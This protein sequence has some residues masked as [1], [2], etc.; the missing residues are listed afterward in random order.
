M[1][2][3]DYE[4]QVLN[5]EDQDSI[6]LIDFLIILAKNKKK[7]F[8]YPIVFGIVGLAISFAL[9]KVYRANI[10]VLPPQQSQSTASA[11]LGQLGSLG[12]AASASLGIKSQN[13]LYIALLKSR[14]LTDKIIKR[15]D[16]QKRYDEEYLE[17]TRKLLDENS[18]IL[19]GKD[20]II[21]I[22]VDDKDPDIAAQIANAYVEELTLLT[23]KFALT[24]ASQRRVFYEKQLELAKDKIIAAE[25]ALSSG[26]DTKGIM[27]VDAQSKAV[28]E[29][30]ARLRANIS[31]KQIQLKAM[32][33][34]VTSNN[35]DYKR[36]NQELLGMQNELAKL[37]N[38]FGSESHSKSDLT[39]QTTQL[40]DKSDDS[41]LVGSNNIELLR[42]VKY[43]QM[44]YEMLSKQYEIARLDEAKDIPI[45]Q[46]LDKAVAPERKIKPQRSL[47]VFVATFLGLIFALISAFLTDALSKQ[48]SEEETKKMQQ[49]KLYLRS[50]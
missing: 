13:D 27:S 7:I 50:R 45:I 26:I 4:P 21:S 19:S 16:L 31:A 9:P 47:I 29:T 10:K 38:G 36:A 15:F 22:D 34:F 17:S 2:I 33:A 18:S 5:N 11:M 49:L 41:A 32:Q 37:E 8:V 39:L 6:S 14:A 43:Y 42:D 30:A 24:E 44:L 46:I 48:K 40:K 25:S 35:L 3:V 12:G 20:N 1:A 23:G 28:L